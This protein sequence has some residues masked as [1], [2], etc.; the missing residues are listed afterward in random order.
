M[1]RFSSLNP[2]SLCGSRPR[3]ARTTKSRKDNIWALNQGCKKLGNDLLPAVSEFAEDLVA[4]G[5]V[6]VTLGADH[7]QG[8][9]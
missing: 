8:A 1:A 3:R 5:V 7:V 9:P 2:Y 4:A 6:E